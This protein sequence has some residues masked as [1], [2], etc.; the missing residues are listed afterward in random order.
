MNISPTRP[1]HLTYCLNV[2]P[3]QTWADNF[4]A[5]RDNALRV[6]DIVCDADTPFGLG[7]RLGKIAADELIQDDKIAEFRE[8]LDANNLYVFTINGFPYG[9]FHEPGVKE[10]VYA[11]D[12]RTDERRD[13]TIQLA[14]ILVELLP[15]GVTGS[16]STVPGSYK[17]WIETPE[18]VEAMVNNL[19]D[20]AGHL[21][22]IRRTRGVSICIALE[23]EPDCFIETSKEVIKFFTGPLREYGKARVRKTLNISGHKAAKL[24]RRHI[25]VC[26]D[27]AHA[28]V[29][30]EDTVEAALAI[31]DENIRIAKVQLSSALHVAIPRDAGAELKDKI[32]AFCDPVY[33]HQTRIRRHDVVYHHHDLP[34][35]LADGDL[36]A[37]DQWRIHFH[38][39]LFFDES[40]GL[41]GTNYLLKG[42]FAELLRRGLTEHLEI[43]TYTFGVLP[44][45][46]RPDDLPPAI[47]KEY[48]WVLSVISEQ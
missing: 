17:A 2:H 41:Q 30:F 10:N 39:P 8:F 4:T 46:L 48:N 45:D 24:L 22:K 37:G 36:H 9:E 16:I 31:N 47:A 23:P 3:G 5:I 32:Q 26:L 28:A 27:T 13:Y 33:L 11:P 38:V 29:E 15:E 25:G 44:D 1:I 20:I 14:D 43:E 40:E 35:A 19:A 18:D 7:M 12:W 21:Y 42:E 34:A 6:R